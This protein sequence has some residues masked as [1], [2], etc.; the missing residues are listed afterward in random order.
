M[1]QQL[2]YHKLL[3]MLL[4]FA[5]LALSI[6]ATSVIIVAYLF[7]GVYVVYL[8]YLGALIFVAECGVKFYLQFR[9]LQNNLEYF[10][11][12]PKTEGSLEPLDISDTVRPVQACIYYHNGASFPVIQR[13]LGM[14][15]PNQARREVIKGL[16]ILLKSYK[17]KQEA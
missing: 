13:N 2:F 3:S 14:K 1:S 7:T 17:E 10:V 12:E 4:S 15:H 11:P 5:V 6:L 8:T 16:D 9:Y